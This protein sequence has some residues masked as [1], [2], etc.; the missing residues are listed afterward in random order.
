MQLED[1]DLYQLGVRLVPTTSS[2]ARSLM[3]FEATH[4]G[5][6][7]AKFDLDSE[8]FKEL[9]YSPVVRYQ[10]RRVLECAL[11]AA[12]RRTNFLCSPRWCQVR[13]SQNMPAT[14]VTV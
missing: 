5:H 4:E 10:R 8:I 7:G 12:E 14:D 1:D 2:T 3:R 9:L 11:A 6:D 13:A